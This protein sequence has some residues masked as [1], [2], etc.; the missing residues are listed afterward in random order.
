[1]P[2]SPTPTSEPLQTV[3]PERLSCLFST[4]KKD[5]SDGLHIH[6]FDHAGN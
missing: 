4:M 1:M 6:K 2:V 3:N 5:N